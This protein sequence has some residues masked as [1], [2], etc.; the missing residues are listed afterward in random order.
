MP[1]DGDGFLALWHARDPT[2]LTFDL[3]EEG[4]AGSV[5]F[6]GFAMPRVDFGGGGEA[7]AFDPAGPDDPD[8]TL[9]ELEEPSRDP[10][11]TMARGG[12]RE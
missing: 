2:R 8:R 3:A 7:C 11:R 12:A 4:P 6:D 10:D 1:A 9:C 5:S